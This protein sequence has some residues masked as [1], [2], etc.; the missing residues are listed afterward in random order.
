M[1]LFQWLPWL[2]M[3]KMQGL[4]FLLCIKYTLL[5]V[6]KD[7]HQDTTAIIVSPNTLKIYLITSK[8]AKESRGST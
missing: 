3:I 2:E 4:V 8:R 5:M 1:I 6:E 7:D